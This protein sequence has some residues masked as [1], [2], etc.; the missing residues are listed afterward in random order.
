MYKHLPAKVD[1]VNQQPISI[2][3]CLDQHT[4]HPLKGSSPSSRLNAGYSD[5]QLGKEELDV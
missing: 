3:Q 2:F 5:R 1:I 4:I